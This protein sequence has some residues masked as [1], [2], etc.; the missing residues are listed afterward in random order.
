MK[1]FLSYSLNDA[2]EFVVPLITSVLQQKGFTVVGSYY[3]ATGVYDKYTSEQ[4]RT[5]NL[6]IGIL[7]LHGTQNGEVYQE[8]GVA[9]NARIPAVLLIDDRLPA[10]DPKLE[11]HP[12]VLRYN[13]AN[14]HPAISR[15][16]L[17]MEP[18]K[19]DK[20]AVEEAA[21]WVL[22]GIALITLLKLLGDE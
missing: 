2:K 13:S 7:T 9:L 18:A 15:V 17:N 16:R 1:V 21:P 10:Y 20:T 8:W 12:N 14:P 6:F 22:G 3:L 5:S 19:R 11:N 4:I